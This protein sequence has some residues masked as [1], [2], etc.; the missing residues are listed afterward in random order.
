MFLHVIIH[1]HLFSVQNNKTSFEKLI[2]SIRNRESEKSTLV[3]QKLDLSEEKS[4]SEDR[5][6]EAQ[7]QNVYGQKCTVRTHII[8]S[9]EEEEEEEAVVD[10][11]CGV[12]EPCG[13]MSPVIENV[14]D[15]ENISDETFDMNYEADRDEALSPVLGRSMVTNCSRKETE[16]SYDAE[17]TVSLTIDMFGKSMLRSSNDK[18][19]SAAQRDENSDTGSSHSISSLSQHAQG[20]VI[21]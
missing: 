1:L 18:C 15:N 2:Q 21:G 17:L 16:T 10:K 20:N 6:K 12:Y 19:N 13:N 4:D 9:D 7:V 11:G 14:S 8:N 3:K 5:N